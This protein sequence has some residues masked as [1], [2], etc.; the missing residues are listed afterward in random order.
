MS[1]SARSA[2]SEIHQRWPCWGARVATP[3][4]TCSLRILCG[5]RTSLP[6]L[7]PAWLL[8]P[9]TDP[10]RV[11]EATCQRLSPRGHRT[12]VSGCSRHQDARRSLGSAGA[13]VAPSKPPPQ[14]CGSHTL[15]PGKAHS[16]VNWSSWEAVMTISPLKTVFMACRKPYLDK[17]S[18][19]RKNN[20][21]S[22]LLGSWLRLSC[23]KEDR[24]TGKKPTEVCM[25]MYA[26]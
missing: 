7:G 5:T 26:S 12:A 14:A 13:P 16:Q 8:P 11:P 20:F 10:N 18:G 9:H 17:L 19:G 24:S 2:L 15:S 3:R 21:P 22:T 23:N 1:L 4:A 25:N 6:T